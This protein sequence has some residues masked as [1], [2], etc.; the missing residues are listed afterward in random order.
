MTLKRLRF[1]Y[2]ENLPQNKLMCF[3]PPEAFTRLVFLFFSL[4]LCMVGF[5]SHSILKWIFVT[6]ACVRSIVTGWVF[7]SKHTTCAEYKWDQNGKRNEK[8]IQ[9]KFHY[10]MT[11]VFS[12]SSFFCSA[13]ASMFAVTKSKQIQNKS[14]PNE[15][16]PK[17]KYKI[18]A[19]AQTHTL[20]QKN[21]WKNNFRKNFSYLNY[22]WMRNHTCKHIKISRNTTWPEV[23]GKKQKCVE[24]L[25]AGIC[26]HAVRL[27]FAYFFGYITCKKTFF[28]RFST[29][30]SVFPFFLLSVF[31]D[32]V[33]LFFAFSFLFFAFSFLS[34]HEY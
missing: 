2:V 3:F 15:N 8:Q 25:F 20:T 18:G 5:F 23:N 28:V 4:A 29:V 26:S 21:E 33:F 24:T 12:S 1:N 10:D 13:S 22:K 31:F 17:I 9:F 7:V 11:S 27:G 19:T 30:V 34:M 14:I 6:V 32:S 16:T